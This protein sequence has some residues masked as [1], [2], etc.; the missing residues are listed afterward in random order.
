MSVAGWEAELRLRFARRGERT[1]L[2]E[3]KHR[4][5]LVVQKPLHPEGP[6]VC[7]AVIVH[8]P[9]GIVGGDALRMNIAVDAVA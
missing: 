3:R 8:P 5:P 7:Q 1:L 9:G 2:A 4:G 6:A